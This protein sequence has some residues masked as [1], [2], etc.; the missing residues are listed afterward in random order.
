MQLARLLVSRNSSNVHCAKADLFSCFGAC[1]VSLVMISMFQ[2]MYCAIKVHMYK[3]SI[4]SQI[5]QIY[6]TH[7]DKAAVSPVTI[8]L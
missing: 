3:M 8:Y 5:F 6:V 2:G 7:R 1:S 4:I